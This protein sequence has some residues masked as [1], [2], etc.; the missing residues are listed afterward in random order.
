MDTFKNHLIKLSYDSYDLDK[1][2]T[3]NKKR[4]KD[5]LVINTTKTII[6]QIC[7]NIIW[8]KVTLK[9]PNKKK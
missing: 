7:F 3:I 5:D 1:K 6:C 2:T 4:A 8:D 9:C